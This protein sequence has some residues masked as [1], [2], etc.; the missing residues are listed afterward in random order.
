MRWSKQFDKVGVASNWYR[1]TVGA[2]LRAI[3]DCF[4]SADPS[5]RRAPRRR[6]IVTLAVGERSRSRIKVLR[7]S[8]MTLEVRGAPRADGK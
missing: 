6:Q 1:Y 3:Y 2:C 8:G 7:T 4:H 5:E